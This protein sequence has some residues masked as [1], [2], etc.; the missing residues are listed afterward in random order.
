[1]L[2]ITL[3][4]VVFRAAAKMMTKKSATTSVQSYNK[5]QSFKSQFT[6][7]S[8]LRIIWLFL[9][10]YAMLNIIKLATEPDLVDIIGAVVSVL[11]IVFAFTFMIKSMKQIKY[12]TADERKDLPFC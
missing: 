3:L 7:F 11:I 4:F 2:V 8:Y 1:M 9:I 12:L 5:I 10:I 6:F